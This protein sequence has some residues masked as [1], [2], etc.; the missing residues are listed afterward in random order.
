MLS[1][2]GSFEGRSY[3]VEAPHTRLQRSMPEL[4]FQPRAHQRTCA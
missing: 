4:D 2:A 1:E 3:A